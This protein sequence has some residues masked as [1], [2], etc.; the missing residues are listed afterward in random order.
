M[1]L[2][3]D[4]VRHCVVC[5]TNASIHFSDLHEGVVPEPVR[6]RHNVASAFAAFKRMNPWYS[7]FAK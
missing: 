4:S 6:C 7:S 1:S 2:Q 3:G 5:G